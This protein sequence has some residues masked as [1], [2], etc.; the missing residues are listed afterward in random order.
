[1]IACGP[2]HQMMNEL[3]GPPSP[4][5]IPLP[6]K[7]PSRDLFLRLE[8]T[9]RDLNLACRTLARTPGFAIVAVV[10]LA[11]GIGVNTA[12]FTLFDAVF[13]RPLPVPDPHQIAVIH[14]TSKKTLYGVDFSFPEYLHIQRENHAFSGLIAWSPITVHLKTDG[15]TE[16]LDGEMVSANYNEVLGVEPIV[17]RDFQPDEGEVPGRHPV[18]LISARLWRV[19]FNS[20]TDIV[21]KTAKLNGNTF[22]L[23]GV[24]PEHFHGLSSRRTDIW[25]PLTMQRQVQPNRWNFDPP[26]W[27]DDPGHTWLNLVGRL[28]PDISWDSAGSSLA[29]LVS[30]LEPLHRRWKEDSLILV[31]GHHTRLYQ[32]LRARLHDIWILLTVIVGAVLLIACANVANLLLSR[33]DSRKLDMAVRLAAGASR[34][35]LIRLLLIETAVL[36]VAA[37]A[38]STLVTLWCLDS[39]GSIPLLTG[40]LHR[41]HLGFGL[42]DGRMLLFTFVLSLTTTTLFGLVPAIRSSRIELFPELKATEPHP[43]GRAGRWRHILVILQVAMS[44]TLL[45]VAAL[46][47]RSLGNRLALDPGFE[48]E[49]VYTVTVDVAT[50]G[51]GEAKGAL[52]FRQLL[53]RV[54]EI[55]AVE[56]ATLATFAPAGDSYAIVSFRT[57]REEP[58]T[59]ELNT[60]FPKYFETVGI[61]LIQGRDFRWTDDQDST[62]VAIISQS[63]AERY[64][65]D[66]DPI[67]KQM[68]PYH[69]DSWRVIGVAHEMQFR[70]V[71]HNPAPQVYFSQL[72]QSGGLMTLMART[73][74]QQASTVVDS[75]RQAVREL[76]ADLPTFGPPSLSARIAQSV[77]QWRLLN[78]LLGTFGVLALT[79][80]AVGLYG[81]LSHS[82]VRRTRELAVRLAMGARRDHT[83]WLILRQALVLVAI[84]LSIGIAAALAGIRMLRNFVAELEPADPMIFL[85]PALVIVVVSLLACAVPAY[86]I[87]RLEPMEALRHE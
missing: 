30:G 42:L 61:P 39:L 43:Q 69:S 65:P 86:R 62:P 10:T 33:A 80:A 25:V 85:I 31:P 55:P 84:G 47:I 3:P 4:A 74:P 66:A 63:L 75:M 71:G 72:Q 26:D 60:V 64:W 77:S 41:A 13:L 50:Q 48:A 45:V 35:H 49:N 27:F 5:G 19:S 76:D 15:L 59:A 40:H 29:A 9:A 16:R 6:G 58:V 54:E 12:V 2:F 53:R 79:L 22:T 57:N 46:L 1:M 7:E 70:R 78:F 81:V 44:T 20:R 24:M 14:T 8:D 34:R 32:P 67:G 36:F 83:V 38:T 52:F 11:L 87:T 51:Y 56:S 28:K 82:V 68:P 17:G 37:G 21:G 23:V 18:A 73:Q